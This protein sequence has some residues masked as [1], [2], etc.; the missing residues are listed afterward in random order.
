MFLHF[1]F[2]GGYNHHPRVEKNTV[3]FRM[4][5]DDK[6]NEDYNTLYTTVFVWFRNRSS[7]IDLPINIGI[8]IMF[9]DRY[10][11]AHFDTATHTYRDSS[12]NWHANNSLQRGHRGR[13]GRIPRCI[14][15]LGRGTTWS[16]S[17][18]PRPGVFCLFRGGITFRRD[19]LCQNRSSY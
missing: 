19:N 7:D 5:V 9:L 8:L 4:D 3:R 13:I 6:K 16:N 10:P 15:G 12:H 14:L 18:W 1:F 17:S 11:H 2:F